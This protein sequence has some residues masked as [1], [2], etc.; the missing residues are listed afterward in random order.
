M[1]T[2]LCVLEIVR[3]ACARRCASR[4][5]HLVQHREVAR[6]LGFPLCALALVL[7]FRHG[8]RPV[9]A[10][11]A[12]AAAAVRGIPTRW[13]AAAARGVTLRRRRRGGRGGRG[14]AR[15]GGRRGAA[16][17][18]RAVPNTRGP[19]SA[20]R[21]RRLPCGGA[22]RGGRRV[23]GRRRRAAV[24]S[25]MRRGGRTGSPVRRTARSAQHRH[26]RGERVNCGS[27]ALLAHEL[28]ALP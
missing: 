4:P 8:T 27:L 9:A 16:G 19:G 10:A 28:E 1:S 18:W 13:T 24:P 26:D 25:Q 3:G 22:R 14:G 12:A 15:L 20:A 11:A 23:A 5:S 6:Q 17:R 21:T 2:R 7:A